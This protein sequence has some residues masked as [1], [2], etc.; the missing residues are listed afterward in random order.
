MMEELKESVHLS[1]A[2]LVVIY[3][4]G[5]EIIPIN[6]V[7]LLIVAIG[8]S[9][10]NEKLREKNILL[11]EIKLIFKLHGKIY[12]DKNMVLLLIILLRNPKH[13]VTTSR[14]KDIILWIKCQATHRRH[15]STQR[16]FQLIR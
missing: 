3:K 8:T 11:E 6:Q 9:V 12:I 10:T 5:F 1:Q 15:M 14:G 2:D 16:A 13:S 7:N 4:G